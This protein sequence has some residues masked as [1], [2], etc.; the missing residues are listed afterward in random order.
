MPDH[1]GKSVTFRE[2]C[3]S[4]R[5]ST[6]KSDRTKRYLDTFR[7][8]PDRFPLLAHKLMVDITKRDLEAA[9]APLPPVARNTAVAQLRS[10]W[11]YSIRQEWA[12]TSPLDKIVKVPEPDFEVTV[13]H[14]D[15]LTAL[16]NAALS[17][18]PELLPLLTVMVFAGVRPA[19]AGKLKWSDIDFEDGIL[20]VPAAVSKTRRE[21]HIEMHETLKK[22]FTWHRNSGG[23]CLGNLNPCN[24]TTLRK[25]LRKIRKDA[26]IE[27]WPQDA[28]RHTFASAALH[29]GWRTIDHLCLELGHSDPTM[30]FAHYNRS[31]KKKMAEAVFGVLPPRDKSSI[32]Q[33]TVAA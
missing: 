11:S 5:T 16:F 2:A 10:L 23:H 8:F 7:R 6:E 33:F 25:Y 3:D 19:E 24:P 9:L 30:L 32:L 17:L 29:G 26:G 15:K 28:L 20:T 13:L 21:R 14:A 4:L 22:W 1:A 31:M 18:H 12:V 27:E